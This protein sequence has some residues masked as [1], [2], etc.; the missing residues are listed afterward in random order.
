MGAIMEH[1]ILLGI[2]V[3]GIFITVYLSVLLTYAMIEV[4]TFFTGEK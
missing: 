3:A 4:I 2:L 1:L